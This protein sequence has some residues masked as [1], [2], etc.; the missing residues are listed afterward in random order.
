[1]SRR[2]LAVALA[3]SGTL[4]ASFLAGFLWVGRTLRQL[5]TGEGRARWAARQLRLDDAQRDAFLRLHADWRS[6]VRKVQRDHR[7]ETDAF[8]AAAMEDGADPAAV[9]ARLAPLLA[10]QRD[11]TVASIDHLLRLLR[12]LTPEQ[13]R[14]LVELIRKRERQL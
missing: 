3:L 2:T 5:E 13:R 7:A 11:T 4:N 8:W 14:A 12:L 6:A 1:M 10:A 9:K